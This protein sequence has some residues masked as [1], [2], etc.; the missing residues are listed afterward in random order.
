MYTSRRF[1]LINSSHKL[2]NFATEVCLKSSRSSIFSRENDSFCRTNV[3]CKVLPDAS[4]VVVH[5]GYGDIGLIE[6]FAK[7]QAAT[8]SR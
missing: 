6:I 2:S 4:I 5:R 1:A 8:K 3:V 7:L